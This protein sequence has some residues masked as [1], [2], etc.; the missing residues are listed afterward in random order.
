MRKSQRLQVIVDLNAANEKTALEELGKWQTKKHEVQAQLESL[1]QYQQEYGDKYQ[2]T[3]QSAINIDKLLEYRAFINKIGKAVEEQEQAV[4]E[5]EDKL[6]LARKS[7]ERQHQKTESLQKV[8]HS[9]LAAEEQIEDKREQR[10][11]DDRSSRK[12]RK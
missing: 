11:Q 2:T 8:C 7:W 3:S 6:G 4:T 1:R 9:A 12:S 10:E 5:I